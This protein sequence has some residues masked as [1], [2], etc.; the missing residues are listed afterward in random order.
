MNIKQTPIYGVMV[1]ETNIKQDSRGAFS[2]L[3]CQR[4]LEPVIGTRS[5][6]QINRSVSHKTGTVRGLHFQRPPCSEMKMI[7]CLNGKVWDVALDLRKA[8]PTFMQ[9]YALELSAE[10]A[11]MLVVPE[12]CAHGFQSLAD[13]SE[14][15]Y[16]HTAYYEPEYEGSVH[17]NDPRAEILWPL[18]VSDISERDRQTVYLPDDFAGLEI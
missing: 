18:S 15:L 3:F 13:D 10:N 1:V 9:W 14:L 2:R 17:Y 8:S 16:L 5:I 6:V 7:R 11:Q 12:G 4:E